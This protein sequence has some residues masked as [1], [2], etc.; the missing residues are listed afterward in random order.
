[1]ARHGA[2][3]LVRAGLERD[4]Q[5]RTPAR[6]D[7]LRLVARLLDRQIVRDLARVLHLKSDLPRLQA[8][9]RGRD[10]ELRLAHRDRA[11]LR[12]G[13]RR[14]CGG[15]AL[16]SGL[17][18]SRPML[19]RFGS[20]RL[21]CR[22]HPEEEHESHHDERQEPAPRVGRPEPRK[23]ERRSQREDDEDARGDPEPD[24]VSR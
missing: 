23:Q 14:R 20:E 15:G 10:L 4:G 6:L 19:R 7:Q 1:M 8:G 18:R 17:R 9:R 3:E 13:R 22:E 5:L 16:P 24:L 11:R 12:L 2:V 21:D